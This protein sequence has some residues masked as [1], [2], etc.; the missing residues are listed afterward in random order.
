MNGMLHVQCALKCLFN[1]GPRIA[2]LGGTKH[3]VMEEYIFK[4]EYLIS[5]ECCLL[6]LLLTNFRFHLP[7]KRTCEAGPFAA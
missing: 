7:F 3:G 5:Q 6:V 1:Y 4:A 2:L